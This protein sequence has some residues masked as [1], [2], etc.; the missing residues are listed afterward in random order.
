MRGGLGT[1]YC[2]H[3]ET[4]AIVNGSYHC[5]CNIDGRCLE[6]SGVNGC[7][8]FSTYTPHFMPTRQD[9][10]NGR[11]AIEVTRTLTLSYL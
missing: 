10:M 3:G 8:D 5:H 11:S 7:D 9:W 4:F 6:C 1:G 2:E